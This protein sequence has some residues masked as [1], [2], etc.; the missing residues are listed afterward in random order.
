M[1]SKINERRRGAK[2]VT[3]RPTSVADVLALLQ[4]HDGDASICM[5]GTDLVPRLQTHGELGRNVICCSRLGQLRR[6]EDTAGFIEVGAG[7]TYRELA[8]NEIVQTALPSL[9]E[10][11]NRIA[12]PR[13]RNRGTLGGVV[14]AARDRSDPPTLLAALSA[15]AVLTSPRGERALPIERLIEGRRATAIA[16]DEF[17]TRI[18]IP[19]PVASGRTGFDRVGST[20]GPLVNIAVSISNDVTRLAVGGVTPAPAVVETDGDPT[21]AQ[22]SEAARVLAERC[23]TADTTLVSQWYGSELAARLVNRLFAAQKGASA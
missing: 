1:T 21:V 18:R 13:V 16:A 8:R 17:L 11:A 20:Q 3:H 12:N 14:C 2:V 4:E 6:V 5:G 22:L 23:W 15:I 7:V 19:S 10:L 9:A